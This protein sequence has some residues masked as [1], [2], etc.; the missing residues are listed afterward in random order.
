MD[1]YLNVEINVG[2]IFVAEIT[3]IEAPVFIKKM[4]KSEHPSVFSQ[5]TFPWTHAEVYSR[6][7]VN[8]R[9]RIFTYNTD[10]I[11]LLIIDKANKTG[12][13]RH[14]EIALLDTSG[15]LLDSDIHPDDLILQ[16]LD[17]GEF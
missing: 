13:T 10:E 15:D 6:D 2:T 4:Y 12:P 14:G 8:F 16:V 7:P 11:D 1:I 3:E 17:F 9:P 5:S